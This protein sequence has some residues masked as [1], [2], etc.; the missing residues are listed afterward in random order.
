MS[1]YK[2]FSAH[3]GS[4]VSLIKYVLNKIM[5]LNIYILVNQELSLFNRQEEFEALGAKK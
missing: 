5:F 3:T 2:K 1:N 4:S